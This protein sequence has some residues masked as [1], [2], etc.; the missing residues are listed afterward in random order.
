MSTGTQ[1]GPCD[2]LCSNEKGF[3]ALGL[4]HV[5]WR[6][7]FAYLFDCWGR[8]YH[9]SCVGHNSGSRAVKKCCPHKPSGH[10]YYL[11][12]TFPR[13]KQGAANICTSPAVKTEANEQGTLLV[14]D[15][16]VVNHRFVTS[17]LRPWLL[18][19]SVFFTFFINE[20]PCSLVIDL[21]DRRLS[22]FCFLGQKIQL[23]KLNTKRDHSMKVDD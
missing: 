22:Y 10:P 6:S 11:K 15:T 17:L 1:F 21:Y 8:Q 4:L 2:S 3:N 18:V 19:L 5:N 16:S 14:P 7:L 12:M 13:S 9:A 23:M 20:P